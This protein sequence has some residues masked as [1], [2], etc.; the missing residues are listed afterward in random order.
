[1]ERLQALGYESQVDVARALI[2]EGSYAGK[3]L[4]AVRTYFN[5]VLSGKRPMSDKLKDA[6]VSITNDDE[7]IINSLDRHYKPTDILD[8]K[9][10]TIFREY[11]SRLD[12]DFR[13]SDRQKRIHLLS[14][15]ERISQSSDKQPT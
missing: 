14:N 8:S 15:L 10:Y 12:C 6:L 13:Q 3:T 5:Q 9:L 2:K 4:N 1:M 7:E 11:V